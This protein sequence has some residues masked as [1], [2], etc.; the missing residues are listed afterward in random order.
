VDEM[1]D[2]P[3]TLVYL[4]GEFLPLCEARVSV[5]DRGFLFGDGIYE[6]IPVFGGAPFRLTEH[7]Q[8][9]DRSLEGIRMVTPLTPEQWTQ[10]FSRLIQGPDDQS[11]YLQITRGTAAKRDHAFSPDLEPTVFVMCTPIQPPPPTG[12]RAITVPDIR[13]QWCHIKAITLLANVLL[14]QQAVDQGCGEAILVKDGYAL[15]GAASNLFMVLDG[16]LITPP[17]TQEILPGITRDLLVELAQAHELD[18]AERPIRVEELLSA[19]EIWVTSSTREILPIVEL[20][21]RTVGTGAPGPVWE[22]MNLLFQAYKQS[23]RTA[24]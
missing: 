19:S 22:R 4:N 15:E 14:R 7:L 1:M 6:V 21:G 11:L 18:H 17:K 8:R 10:I 24:P 9:L 13:W 20:D 23:L 2:L 16:V 3:D 5:L 12:A